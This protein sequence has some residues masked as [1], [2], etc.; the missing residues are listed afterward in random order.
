MMMIASYESNIEF[1]H[2]LPLLI[3][4][5]LIQCLR[6]NI[7]NG[8]VDASTS[9][10]FSECPPIHFI[11]IKVIIILPGPAKSQLLLLH[12]TTTAAALSVSLVEA[13]GERGCPLS[14][15]WIFFLFWRL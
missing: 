11:N 8:A 14:G 12:S 13:S 7:Y 4:I 10:S 1:S 9:D 6:N 15:G 2:S 5:E 3:K